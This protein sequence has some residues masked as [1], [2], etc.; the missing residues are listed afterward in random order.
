MPR[1]RS[2]AYSELKIGILAVTA[3]IIAA[4]VI[5]ML[6]GQ[7]GFPWQRF[8]L[9][10]RFPNVAGLKPGAPVRLAG[11]EVGSVNAIHLAG[12]VVDVQFE[13]A[14]DYAPEITTDSWT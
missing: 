2:L 1:T 11:I 13:V 3:L 14:R 7:G 10:A 4:V 8:Q 12:A 5:F 6:S 9:K